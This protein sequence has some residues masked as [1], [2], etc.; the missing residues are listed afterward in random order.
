MV[1]ADI[2]GLKQSHHRPLGRYVPLG[3]GRYHG[4]GQSHSKE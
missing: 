1:E 3:K 4:V 2:V